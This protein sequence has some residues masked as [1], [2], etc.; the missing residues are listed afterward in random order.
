M[1]L[2]VLKVIVHAAPR[3]KKCHVK[4]IKISRVLRSSLDSIACPH[5]G[6][7]LPSFES[8]LKGVTGF[9]PSDYFYDVRLARVFRASGEYLG[10]PATFPSRMF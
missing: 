10:I 8:A 4:Q 6:Y 2:L 7:T 5:R 9:L 1:T 3:R